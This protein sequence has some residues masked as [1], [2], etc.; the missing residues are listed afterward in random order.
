MLFI[1][2]WALT[3]LFTWLSMGQSQT[4]RF[5]LKYLK[6]CSEDDKIVILAWKKLFSEALLWEGLL[7]HGKI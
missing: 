6:L 1:L 5:H 4:S 2:F 3:V 7:G